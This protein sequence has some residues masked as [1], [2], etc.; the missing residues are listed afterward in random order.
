MF[1]TF[2]TEFPT[3]SYPPKLG[4]SLSSKHA[5]YEHEIIKI[6]FTDWATQY[7]SVSDGTPVIITLTGEGGFRKFN[8]YVHH[9][10]PDISPDKNYLDVTFIGA[11]KVF[12]QQSQRVWLS[13]TAD[14]IIADLALSHEF[15]YIATPH[16]RV[17]DQVSQSNMTDWQ[18]MVKLAKQCG[19]MLK[20]DN[21]T[22]I[23]QP[24]MQDFT[25]YRTQASYYSLKGLDSKHTGI[26]QFSP[27][28]GE[29][30]PY[31]DSLKSTTTVAGVNRE[32]ASI[33]SHTN[34]DQIKKTRISYV[35]P[36]YDNY[37]VDIVAPS[38]AI[39]QYEAAAS[40]ERSRYAYRGFVEVV[41]SPNVLPGNPVFLDGLG[42]TYTGYWTVLS[43]EN[44]IF[45][46]T[47][48]STTFMVGTDSLGT[49]S[50]WVDNK[51]VSSPSS[52]IQRVITPGVRQKNVIPKTNLIQ[53]GLSVKD[54]VKSPYPQKKTTSKVSIT[55]VPNYKWKGL[56]GN[57]K[58]PVIKE[59][60]VSPGALNRMRALYG[61]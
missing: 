53:S 26:Y 39:A 34:Q 12:K 44:N 58:T 24:L 40:D 20:A 55:S 18:L 54:S 30:I 16:P 9:A 52:G 36:I 27:M 6:R 57:L 35:D 45:G 51:N 19:Y 7:N 4:Y 46:N 48:F 59:P 42:K 31:E 29:A 22:L 15:S 1:K 5:L 8:G 28:I 23:F 49:S 33:H 43:V 61:R 14:Q 10:T 2:T 25:D 50:Q 38:Y 47:S 56:G 32:S 60:P 21:T 41:G 11:S 37:S 13:A 17:Y 3:L